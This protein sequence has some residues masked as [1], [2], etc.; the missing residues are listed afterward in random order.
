MKAL[1]EGDDSFAKY[2]E[3]PNEKDPKFKVGDHVRISNFKN[4]FAKVY[5]VQK[6]ERRNL[7]C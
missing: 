4:V 2:N 5:T 6:L 3:E 1:D 7:C